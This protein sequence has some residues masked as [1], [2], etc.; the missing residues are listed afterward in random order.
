MSLSLS[1]LDDLIDALLS[2]AG[3]LVTES[4]LLGENGHF[5]RAYAL[6]HMAREELAKSMM[7]QAAAFKVLAGAPIDWA[8]LMKRFRSHDDK[9]KLEGVQS[10]TLLSAV[11]HIDQGSLVLRHAAE[12][13]KYRNQRKNT[14][15]YVELAEGKVSKP[16]DQFSEQQASR[17]F[18][19]AQMW[20]QEQQAMRQK[21]G[22]YDK[23]DPKRFK[24]MKIPDTQQILKGDPEELLKT[25]GA[26]QAAIWEHQKKAHDEG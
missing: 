26:A 7:L 6:A 10:A 25:L 21:I 14:A 23:C 3:D 4:A 1:N 18:Q 16:S 24:D 22:R 2:N 11:G 17:T 20:L 5:A 9:L 19:L 15:M 12:L 8:K 13:A